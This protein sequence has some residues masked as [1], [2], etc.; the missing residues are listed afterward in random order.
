MNIADV[1]VSLLRY[2]LDKPVGG[3]GVAA[4]DVILARVSLSDGSEGLGFSY[5]LG[6]G[7]EVALHAAR[8][9]AAAHL[10]GKALHH[11]EAA[12]RRMAASLNRTRRGPNFIGLAALDVALWDAHARSL[13]LPIG[14]A[15]GGA[16]REVPVYGSGGFNAKQSPDEA[17]H[18]AREHVERGFRAVKP[19]VAALASDERLIA[20]VRDSIP[21][22][23]DVM[24]D[25][26]EKAT[27]TAAHRMLQ[28]AAAHRV[29]FVEEPLPADDVA[30]YRALA[31]AF[32]RLVATGEHL[33]GAGEMLPFIAEGL[34]GL[35]QPDLAMVGG[36]TEALRIA[37]LAETFGIEVSPHFLPGLFIHL[38][39][40]APNV[41]WLEDFPLIEPLFNGWPTMSKQ[42]TLELP[43]GAG[44]GLALA[45][46]AEK[47]FS[48]SI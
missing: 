11:P 25:A 34:C 39:A 21:A 17:A 20:Q 15:M 24:I 32:P 43:D 18:A 16:P 6:G 9:L 35:A 28:V 29:L 46:G 45:D 31:R 22:G 13:N 19:R 40:A 14:I 36:L 44:H 27:A 47:A 3:S 30:G 1:R 4:V 26:N 41:T 23:V 48:L 12:W 33:Q 42:G 7:G 38:A 37:R 10:H 5:V 2:R 8:E